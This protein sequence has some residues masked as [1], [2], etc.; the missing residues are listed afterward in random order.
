MRTESS[1]VSILFTDPNWI[2]AAISALAIVISLLALGA[3]YGQYRVTKMQYQSDKNHRLREQARKVT[4]RANFREDNN[5][6]ADFTL[7]NSSESPIF[8]I[9]FV[10]LFEQDWY[11]KGLDFHN[12]PKIYPDRRCYH[13]GTKGLLSWP[14]P[15]AHINNISVVEYEWDA[16]D[17]GSHQFLVEFVDGFRPLPFRS[18]MG[19]VF[20][21]VD[22]N[23]W[24]RRLDGSLF[25]GISLGGRHV[26]RT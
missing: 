7:Y 18:N 14:N 20:K 21:D 25:S 16:L 17:M 26:Y 8:L 11:E 1:E 9:G 12:K 6:M 4:V 3:S 24:T 22:G 19:L 10:L 13:C 5:S 2:I 15:W 23:L